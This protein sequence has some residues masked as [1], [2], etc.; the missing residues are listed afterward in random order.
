M[1]VFAYISRRYA[2]IIYAMPLLPLSRCYAVTLFRHAARRR[3]S[4][5]CLLR[6]YSS[7]FAA[8]A[9]AACLLMLLFRRYF[10]GV[11]RAEATLRDA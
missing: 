4:A 3:Y 8:I 7:C 9:R 5:S 2:F 11:E 1:S 10:D 6:Y